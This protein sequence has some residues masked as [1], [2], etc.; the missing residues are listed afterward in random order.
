MDHRRWT[1]TEWP[2]PGFSIGPCLASPNQDLRPR[3]GLYSGGTYG[4]LEHLSDH[5]AIFSLLGI[6]APSGRA[7]VPEVTLMKLLPPGCVELLDSA[8]VSFFRSRLYS[9][10]LS[11]HPRASSLRLM[12]DIPSGCSYPVVPS[13][14]NPVSP[15]L[16][17][18]APPF[19]ALSPPASE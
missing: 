8:G 7:T 5:L 11:S 12:P 9:R 4:P 1:G 17:R 15:R 18:R 19:L 13:K 2:P 3:Y 6:V 16:S 10:F 14:C